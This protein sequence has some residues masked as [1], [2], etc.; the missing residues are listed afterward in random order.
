MPLQSSATNSALLTAA[1][2][3]VQLRDILQ[4]VKESLRE[5]TSVAVR[6]GPWSLDVHPEEDPIPEPFELEAD[7]DR[8]MKVSTS[9]L[10]AAVCS[11]LWSCRLAFRVL[12][13]PLLQSSRRH[14]A[15]LFAA[16]QANTGRACPRLL[17]EAA[18]MNGRVLVFQL[19]PVAVLRAGFLTG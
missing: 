7:Y 10:P 4:S 13:R 2:A 17:C 19:V 18:H 15:F 3:P 6:P 9:H 16:S 8:M 11:S 14:Q 1:H 5:D 12:L